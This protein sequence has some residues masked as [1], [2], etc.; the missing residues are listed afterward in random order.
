MS[1][2]ESNSQG[3]GER[4]D[5]RKNRNLYTYLICVIIAAVFWLLNALTKE[6][7]TE[8]ELP[9][10]YVNIPENFV[11]E[12]S[13]PSVVNAQVKGFGFNILFYRAS[14]DVDSVRL[15]FQSANRSFSN[16]D[17]F[18]KLPT[19]PALKTH[20][21]KLPSNIQLL[22]FWEDTLFISAEVRRTR[23]IPLKAQL[24]LGFERQHV[25]DG[26]VTIEP[27][28]VSVTG[29]ASLV[30]KLEFV[31]LK[32]IEL[33]DLNSDISVE[34]EVEA[35]DLVQIDREF[36]TVFIPVDQTSEMEFEVALKQ[37]NLPDSLSLL[38][39]PSRATVLCELPLSKFELLD[40]TDLVFVVDF[41][42]YE[43]GRARLPIKQESIPP[44]VTVK[45][46]QPKRVEIIVKK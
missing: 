14:K 1:S 19:A 30:D 24:E 5:F 31:P 8:L 7:V 25:Q 37:R 13:I 40:R 3:F 9:L 46:I 12:S 2:T 4:L 29:P 36:A 11:F 23:S 10:D 16:G 26:P 33:L 41:E 6:Y 38:L 28:R 15:D 21:S 34:A 20:L 22:K 44:Y 35:L 42:D 43:P 18:C 45:S 27:E 17:M 32:P 39:F